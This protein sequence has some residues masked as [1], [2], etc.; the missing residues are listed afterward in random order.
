MLKSVRFVNWKSF[1]DATL[2]I[3][4]LT[5][6]IGGNSSGKSNAI[7]G[8]QLLSRLA[9]GVPT[10]TA[11]AG[12]DKMPGLRGGTDWAG[13]RG[14]PKIQFE[15]SVF[16]EALSTDIVHKY[17]LT[18]K[19]Q[20]KFEEKN[21]ILKDGEYIDC[22]SS[23]F[24]DEVISALHEERITLP[25]M[26]AGNGLL[27]GVTTASI[28]NYVLNNRKKFRDMTKD[29]LNYFSIVDQ[30]LPLRRLFV[31]EPNPLQMRGLSGNAEELLSDGSNIAGVIAGLPDAEQQQVLDTLSSFL[32]RLPEFQVKRVFIEKYGLHKNDAMLCCEE[33]WEYP[34]DARCM[35]DGTLRF[36]AILVAIL[37]LPKGSL[38]VIE[39]VDTGI[40]PS[41]A[42]LVLE[43]LRSEGKRRSVDVLVTTHNVA[44]LDALPPELSPFVTVAYR[45]A[46]TGESQLKPLDELGEY[47]RIVAAGSI[48]RAVVRGV[49]ARAVQHESSPKP[50]EP[51]SVDSQ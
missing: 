31:L 19:P 13:F 34:I 51:S 42:G 1:R 29:D 28:F 39:D 40:H 35:S 16:S 8:L 23:L 4:P 27:N 26:I 44:F 10:E 6:L 43:V 48:G 45:D 32:S 14:A 9:Q 12:S 11:L 17:D 18:I 25:I 37:T 21:L 46:Q 49:V 30:I 33:S 50:S 24:R 5:V 15:L 7:E 2:H 41:R 22:L 36:V 20:I 47:G 38:L 3:D